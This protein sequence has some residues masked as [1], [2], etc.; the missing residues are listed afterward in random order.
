MTQDVSW[1]KAS[2]GG[3]IVGKEEIRAYWS[4]QWGEFEPYVEALAITEGGGGK[5]RIRL[6]RIV[7][8]ILRD[9]LSGSEVFHV[10]TVNADLSQ[11]WTSR[12]RLVQLLVEN[13]ELAA[14]HTLCATG[15]LPISRQVITDGMRRPVSSGM[16]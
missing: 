8:N 1:P 5:V 2:E 15:L 11:T 4:R 16:R 14:D 9:V 12:M 6:H 10:Y 13:E 7:K 3:K